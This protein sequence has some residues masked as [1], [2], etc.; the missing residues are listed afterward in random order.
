MQ[1][2]LYVGPTRPSMLYGI[3]FEAWIAIALTTALPFILTSNFIFF[4]LGPVLYGVSWLVVMRE[5]RGFELLM[6]WADTKAT[7][8]S[9][10][11][12][13]APSRGPM[14]SRRQL[15]RAR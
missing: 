12:W 14:V 10:G 13:G 7:S 6:K 15:R 1:D 2:R 4:A 3:P 8:I 5:P 9:R 11:H